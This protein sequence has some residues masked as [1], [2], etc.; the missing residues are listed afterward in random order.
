M[1][2]GRSFASSSVPRHLVR[3]VVGFG[4]RQGEASSGKAVEDEA[5]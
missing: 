3:G 2:D 4:A 5:Q 1:T